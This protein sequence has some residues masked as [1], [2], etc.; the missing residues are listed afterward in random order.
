M[1]TLRWKWNLLIIEKKRRESTAWIWKTSEEG[2]SEEKKRVYKSVE[3]PP[4][5]SVIFPWHKIPSLRPDKFTGK[6]AMSHIFCIVSIVMRSD[7]TV[8]STT[9][10]ICKQNTYIWIPSVRVSSRGFL[11]K[12]SKVAAKAIPPIHKIEFSSHQHK[13]NKH[14]EYNIKF[15]ELLPTSL[16]SRTLT[17][18]SSSGSSLLLLLLFLAGC[19][20]FKYKQKKT[21]SSRHITYRSC[22]CLS[23]DNKHLQYCL[24]LRPH[25]RA[26]WKFLSVIFCLPFVISSAVGVEMRFMR[27]MWLNRT[28]FMSSHP[29]KHTS[30]ESSYKYKEKESRNYM[31]WNHVI[32]WCW[33]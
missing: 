29:S 11:G 2:K 24:V 23:G 10:R 13:G 3:F 17:I 5:M 28:I 6:R 12:L 9:S 7:A 30:T 20:V 21:C 18:L 25:R 16:Y 19:V 8:I 22:P 27:C 4:A 31:E 14:T 33:T 1:R 15:Y 26:Y 32:L